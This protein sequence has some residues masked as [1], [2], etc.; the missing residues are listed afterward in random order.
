M[1]EVEGSQTSSE[2]KKLGLE[3]WD[4]QVIVIYNDYMSNYVRLE[5]ILRRFKEQSLDW[6]GCTVY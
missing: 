6:D 5:W 4:L 3:L 1:L 2:M